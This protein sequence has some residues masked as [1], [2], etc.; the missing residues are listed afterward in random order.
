LVRQLE[1]TGRYRILKKLRL[2]PV[3]GRSTSTFPRLGICVDTETTGLDP[4]KDEVIKLGIVAF[5]YNDHGVVGDIVGV[6]SAL[7]QPYAPIPPEITRL[8]G[9]INEMVVGKTINPE[10]VE[11]FIAPADLVIAHNS[12]FDR[13]F[14]ERLSPG[15]VAK[16]WACSV[17]EIAWDDRGFEGTKLAYLIAQCGFFH[18]GHRAIENSPFDM[19]EKLKSRRYKWSDGNGQPKAWWIDVSDNNLAEELRFLRQEIYRWEDA[20]PP[21]KRLAAAIALRAEAETL[22]GSLIASEPQ[23]RP[24]TV[25]PIAY[26]VLRRS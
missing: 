19:K 5:T 2:R 8:T 6:F 24:M 10:D 18:D 25:N 1:A 22:L 9:I 16:P 4:S 7:R 20:E 21:S 11:A 13:P 3:I 17:S 12:K 14:C 23:E 26:P 15:F